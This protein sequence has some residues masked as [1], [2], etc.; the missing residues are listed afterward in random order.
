QLRAAWTHGGGTW[1]LPGGARDSHEDVI[2]A[3]LREAAEEVGVDYSRVE[4][5]KIFS[6]DTAT[7]D[8]TR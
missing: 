6:D 3:A 8:M 1:A 4:V 2:T 5:R 7:G